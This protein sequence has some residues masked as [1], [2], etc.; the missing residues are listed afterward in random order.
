MFFEG[1]T[2]F[3]EAQLYSA[4][5]ARAKKDNLS[6]K[7]THADGTIGNI[8]VGDIWNSSIRTTEENSKTGLTLHPN[9]KQFIVVEAKINSK[10]ASGTAHVPFYNQAT[11]NIACMAKT[12]KRSKIKPDKIDDLAFFVIVPKMQIK[13]I[14]TFKDFTDKNMVIKVVKD[15]VEQYKNDDYYVQ[16]QEWLNLWFLP[17]MNKIKINCL[18]WEDI[19]HFIKSNDKIYGYELEEFYDNCL[20]YN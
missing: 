5:L 19:I 16:L 13:K 10:L 11:R 7:H 20:K 6:E 17:M 14:S 9:V 15:R 18:E 2:W 3:S 1:S 8:L 12:L 4:F